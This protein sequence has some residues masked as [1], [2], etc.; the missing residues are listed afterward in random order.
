MHTT[1]KIEFLESDNFIDIVYIISLT[2]TVKGLLD[3]VLRKK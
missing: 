1:V 3:I 2:A